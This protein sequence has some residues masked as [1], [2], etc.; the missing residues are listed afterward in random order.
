MGG[1]TALGRQPSSLLF[2]C[3]SLLLALPGCADPSTLV[4]GG[5]LLGLPEEG[6]EI[7]VFVGRGSSPLEVAGSSLSRVGTVTATST[8]GSFAI[9]YVADG[10]HL[11]TAER[12]PALRYESGAAWTLAVQPDRGVGGSTTFTSPPPAELFGAPLDGRWPQREALVLATP[13]AGADRGFAWVNG[14][15]G[16]VTWTD[17]PPTTGDLLRWLD[18]DEGYPEARIPA[19]AFPTPGTHR[20]FVVAA[21][22]EPLPADGGFAARSTVSAGVATE[23]VLEIE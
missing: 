11:Q 18:A 9:P 12:E 5:F 19:E 10:F 23:L 22:S 14:P 13:L 2:A 16:E 17:E 8:R 21:S 3:A 4:L 15:D 20:V 6:A 7:T 1:S